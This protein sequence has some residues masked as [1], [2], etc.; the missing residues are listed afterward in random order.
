MVPDLE[1]FQELNLRNTSLSIVLPL[2]KC[3]L[4]KY[5]PFEFLEQPPSPT[6]QINESII[7]LK[8]LKKDG[9][10]SVD[11]TKGLTFQQAQSAFEAIS[12]LHALSLVMKVN[13]SPLL[14]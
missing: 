4:G 13:D 10:Y 2:P 6:N 1:E 7:I 9:Y 12:R 8:N 11:F 5:V 3:Y 14:L